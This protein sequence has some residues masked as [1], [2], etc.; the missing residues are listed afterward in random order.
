MGAMD[1]RFAAD[2]W[3]EFCSIMA[4]ET[5]Q[6]ADTAAPHLKQ[7]YLGIAQEWLRLA[8]AM[9]RDNSN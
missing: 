5:M 9:K 4:R 2:E 1:R 3:S 8:E 7:D 6:L